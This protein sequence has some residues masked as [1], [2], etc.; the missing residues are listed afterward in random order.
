M[1][2]NAGADIDVRN[3]AGYTLLHQAIMKHDGAMA[4]FLLQHGA[5]FTARSRTGETYLQFAVR[6]RLASIVHELCSLG[7]D[8]NVRSATSGDPVL[9]EALAL[10]K[11]VVSVTDGDGVSKNSRYV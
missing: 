1:L 10:M 6:H 2:I 9:W 3:E 5:D 7:A 11:E 4:H 8:V